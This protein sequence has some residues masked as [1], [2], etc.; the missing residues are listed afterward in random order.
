[1]AE[2]E[3]RV[4]YNEGIV[5]TGPYAINT[6]NQIVKPPPQIRPA[7]EVEAPA[8]L[9][10][11]RQA[12]STQTLFVGRSAELAALTDALEHGHG[13]ITQAITGLGGIGKSTLAERYVLTR[14]DRYNPIWWL[15]A[16][17][18]GRLEAGLAALARRLHPELGGHPELT[19]VQWCLTWLDTHDGWLLVL[20]NVSRPAEVAELVGSHTRGRFLVTSRQTGGWAG[21]AVP[22]RLDVLP[23]AQAR[24]LLGRLVADERLLDGADE[25]CA[26]LDGLPL[27]VE[28][29]GG[30]LAQNGVTAGAY[31]DRLT[32]SADAWSW[33]PTGGDPQRTVGR[34]WQVTFDRIAVEHGPE[35]GMLLR[36]LAWYAADGVPLTLLGHALPSEGPAPVWESEVDE[37]V[38]AAVDEAVGRLAAYG[39]VTR[40]RDTVAVHRLVQAVNRTAG[41]DGFRAAGAALEA[42]W[43]LCESSAEQ[44]RLA[45]HLEVAIGH[46]VLL[47]SQPDALALA[48][49]LADLLVDLEGSRVRAVGQLAAI[50]GRQHRLL[51]PGHADVFYTRT[52]HARGD[53]R[54]DALGPDVE[55]LEAVAADAKKATG[56]R[57]AATVHAQTH[58]ALAYAARGADTRARRLIRRSLSDASKEFGP[59][60]RL[61]I[62]LR[63]HLKGLYEADVRWAYGKR[64]FRLRTFRSFLAAAL[65]HEALLASVERVYGRGHPVVLDLRYEFGRFHDQYGNEERAA[66]LYTE[67]LA[68][69]DVQGRSDLPY[70]RTVR[71]T[72]ARLY[73]YSRHP[74]RAVPLYEQLA[75][76]P[77]LPHRDLLEVLEHLGRLQ[78]AGGDVNAAAATFERIIAA[79]EDHD[80]PDAATTLFFLQCVA[81]EFRD[82][83]RPALAEPWYERLAAARQRTGSAPR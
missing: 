61:T 34:V 57:S 45:P 23:P 47:S 25:L 6:I 54:P 11:L 46:V 40:D 75:A 81:E 8:G 56:R 13:G 1:M 19:A 41:P 68:W 16:D 3:V 9:V 27:A 26:A 77:D 64:L 83:G 29:A 30:Y 69:L 50:L 58:A 60:H 79:R 22:T 52:A 28:L 21:L 39:L 44:E 31:L 4:E 32:R 49:R 10:R 36:A 35:P 14:R 15:A 37:Q 43:A 74:E 72:L 73:L 20:D 65:H 18:P 48:S 12:G 63:F 66:A 17:S 62:T 24:E 7:A 55:K 76:A 38:R 42:A 82:A 5:S 53:R 67:V 51:G 70:T 33:V 59:D 71:A 2:R 78:V 80:G